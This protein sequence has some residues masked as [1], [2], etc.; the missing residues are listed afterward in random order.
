MGHRLEDEAKS[1]EHGTNTGAGGGV[2]ARNLVQLFV[3]VLGV[4]ETEGEH[5]GKPVGRAYV[6][7]ARTGDDARRTDLRL[8]LR[9]HGADAV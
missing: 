2:G 7:I 1:H 3:G 9:E 8:V 5:G 4:A 6:V